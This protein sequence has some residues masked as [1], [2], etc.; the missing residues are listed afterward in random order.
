M[1]QPLIQLLT[2]KIFLSIF[3][4][5]FIAQTLK[6]IIR[7]KKERKI[8]L[9]YYLD[10]SGMPSSHSAS[11]V[12]MSFGIYLSEG[13]SSLFVASILITLLVIREA[14]GF[15]KISE[16]ANLINY[17]QI[18]LSIQEETKIKAKEDIGHTVNEVIIGSILG[19]IITYI[20]FVI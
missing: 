19:L 20:I 12:A 1:P 16:I 8:K 6:I 11:F 10:G 7:A 4:S 9:I 15:K 2:N 5:W 3:F 17:I 13:V 14:I 18:N